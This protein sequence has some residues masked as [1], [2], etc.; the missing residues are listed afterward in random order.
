MAQRYC[1]IKGHEQFQVNHICIFENY[2][3]GSRWNCS[4]C[5]AKRMHSHNQDSILSTTEFSDL[6]KEQIKKAQENYKNNHQINQLL[7]Q[8]IR[9]KEYLEQCRFILEEQLDQLISQKDRQVLQQ[10]LNQSQYHNIL[11]LEKNQINQILRAFSYEFTEAKQKT[12]KLPI[13]TIKQ[14]ITQLEEEIQ[15]QNRFR[16]Y[17]ILEI[18]ET[19]YSYYASSISKN[20][21]YLAYGGSEH[22]IKI[23]NLRS[24]NQCG[25]FQLE[26]VCLT[27]QFTED[28]AFLYAGDSLGIIYQYDVQNQFKN[29]YQKK[30][31]DS[32]IWSIL[33]TQNKYLISCSSDKSIIKTDLKS[34]QQINIINLMEIALTIQYR[35]FSDVIICG[36]YDGSIIFQKFTDSYSLIKKERAHQT[37]IRQIQLFDNNT[38]LSLDD[39]GNLS[40]WSFDLDNSSVQLTMEITNYNRIQNFFQFKD[41]NMILIN[42][43][44]VVFLNNQG[45]SICRIDHNQEGNSGNQDYKQI[46]SS[47]YII[48]NSHKK[49]NLLIIK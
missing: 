17:Q 7:L 41:K 24:M 33:L 42:N 22:Q 30:L 15:K 27:C 37:L 18:D 25:V 20:E 12:I 39:N 10:Y 31:H 44:Q 40:Q 14:S 28:S 6:I 11:L 9:L 43:K 8:I 5:L 2:Q 36:L 19:E 47:R 45:E 21:Q 29:I 32:D 23:Y 16:M 46:E 35:F 34:N 4:Q 1:Q 38:L 49:M 13:D 48:I 26:G 3:E